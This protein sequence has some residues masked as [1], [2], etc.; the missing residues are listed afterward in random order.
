M[1]LMLNII[2]DICDRNFLSA[3]STQNSD[4]YDEKIFQLSSFIE[5]L[6]CVCSQIDSFS[7]GSLNTMEKLVI[8]AIDC[9][10]KLVKRYNN[11]ISLAIASLF[12]AVKRT[13]FSDEFISRIIFHS[14]IR[15]FSYKT[16]Y[17]FQEES[18][19]DEADE[20]ASSVIFVTSLD[21]VK[22]W[23]NFLSLHEFSDLKSE[24]LDDRKKIVE[25][26]YNE[27][28]ESII[29]IM[30]KLDLAA[31]KNDGSEV[32]SSEQESMEKSQNDLSIS[33]DPISGLKPQKPKD[34]EI[35][36]NLVDFTKYF[37]YF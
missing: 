4:I 23:S 11:Q 22:L 27:Y 20:P 10:P 36:I 31:I 25:T 12:L 35:F 2:V 19:T 14:L 5:S 30:N 32:I 33:S 13:S 7:E 16:L 29:K 37:L 8:L 6:A 34:F 24:N 17:S 21:Y 15:I 26:I 1:K 28:V 9:Y 18:G 3:D